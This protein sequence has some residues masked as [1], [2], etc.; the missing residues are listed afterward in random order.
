MGG[1]AIAVGWGTG[2][3]GIPRK[4]ASAPYTPKDGPADIGAAFRRAGAASGRYGALARLVEGGCQP[5]DGLDQLAQLPDGM[6]VETLGSFDEGSD[7]FVDTAAIMQNL[8]LIV[9]SDTAIAHLAGALG[10]PVWVAL[11][12]VP[13]WRWMLDRSDTPWYPTMRL[14]RQSVR[15]RWEDVFF[16]VAEALRELVQSRRSV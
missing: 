6:V 14:F 11:K 4:R 1:T 5:F 13:D 10:R 8:D 16:A 12:H 2:G 7:A 9:T 15:G 3:V